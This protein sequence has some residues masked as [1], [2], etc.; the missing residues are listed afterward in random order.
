MADA[1]SVWFI[2]TPILP[3]I[4]SIF[5]FQMWSRSRALLSR[6]VSYRDLETPVRDWGFHGRILPATPHMAVGYVLEA[7]FF[8]MLL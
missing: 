5:H 2:L 1:A 8:V 7:C 4:V 3:R 6:D